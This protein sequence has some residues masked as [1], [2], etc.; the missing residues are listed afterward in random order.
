MRVGWGGGYLNYSLI[1]AGPE[2]RH[3]WGAGDDM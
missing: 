3:K 2:P 1:G